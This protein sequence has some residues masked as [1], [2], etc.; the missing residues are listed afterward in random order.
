MQCNFICNFYQ[1][2]NVIK[3]VNTRSGYSQSEAISSDCRWVSNESHMRNFLCLC[4][5]TMKC[6]L[7]GRRCCTE[8]FNQQRA[9]HI[10]PQKMHGASSSINGCA[11][12]Y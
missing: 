12:W 4:R 11:A 7:T 9:D 10:T 8:P 1:S 5:M 2:E 3:L 6:V